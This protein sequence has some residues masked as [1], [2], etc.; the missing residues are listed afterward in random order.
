MIGVKEIFWKALQ[1]LEHN[2]SHYTTLSLFGR[3]LQLCPRCTGT[4]LGIIFSLP[5]VLYLYLNYS[6]DFNSIF[7]ISWFMVL[8]PILDW[9]SVKTGLWKGNNN[10]RIVTG[11]MLGSAGLI[12]LFLL[13]I[14]VASPI[15]LGFKYLT[16][17]AYGF[18]FSMAHYGIKCK[19]LDLH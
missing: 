2:P 7:I 10:V 11:F 15:S 5:F 16:L 19:E 13:P 14:N 1:T 8:F 4:Y 17:C 12:Y 6:F 3:Q 18:V 9:A